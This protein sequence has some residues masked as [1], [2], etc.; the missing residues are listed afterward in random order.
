MKTKVLPVLL[1]AVALVYPATAA[2]A[3]PPNDQRAT[4]RA[5]TLPV[6]LTGTTQDATL[7]ADE[8][9]TCSPLKGSVWYQVQATDATRIV[10]RLRAQGDLDGSVDVLRRVRSQL[11]PVTCEPTDDDG[12]AELSFKP[13]PG[14]I[15][16]VRV[17]QRSN[18]VPGAF[19]LDVSAPAPP[20]TVPG[21]LLP[22]GGVS[23]SLDAVQ[24]TA[25]AWSFRMRVG[26]TYRVN[27]TAAE[28]TCVSAALYATGVKDF[29]SDDPVRTAR[30]GGYLLYTPVAGAGGRYSI[31]LSAQP[32]RR[33]PQTYHVQVARAAGDDTAPGL[34]LANYERARGALRGSG[35]DAVDLYHFSLARRSDL[36]VRLGADRFTLRLL[37]D[38]GRRIATGSGSEG[39]RRRL[40][41]GRYFIAVSAAA[42][43]N[44]GYVL[45]RAARTITRTSVSMPA[46]RTPGAAVP[47]TAR[48][49]PATGGVVRFT[50]E[51]FDPLAGWL[52][53]VQRDVTA[54]GGVARTSF[55]PAGEG[56]YRATAAFLGSRTA[57]PS[58]AGYARTLVAGR[59]SAASAV[60]PARSR[61]P[62]HPG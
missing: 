24:N 2:A 13:E 61:E 46:R 26:T 57:A 59:L 50:V 21:P 51:R 8:P 22:R 30:C 33:G 11:R 37:S 58:Q 29:E 39:I 14:G 42:G 32:R 6:S 5:L 19:R 48:V 12:Q 38:T 7:E 17:G 27:V 4:P 31:L 9:S 40:R 36:S 3:P 52:F 1:T 45:Q 23:R 35:V 55:T 16:L 47:V 41:A 44:G 18:S 62:A 43:E 25:D 54:S 60:G 28:G 56:R 53:L 10:V 49:T 15:Y 20:P 34:S